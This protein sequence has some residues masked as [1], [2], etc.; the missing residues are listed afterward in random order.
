MNRRQ[1][2][3]LI[4]LGGLTAMLASAAEKPNFTGSWKLNVSKSDFGPVP[5]PEKLEQTIKHE[6]P[7]L[8]INTLNVGQQGEIKSETTY[9]T[10]GKESINKQAGVETK[11]VAVWD[12]DKL[13]IK[14]KRE[15]QGMEI[16]F[17]DT[18]TLGAEGKSYTIVRDLSTPQ[19]D[20]KLTIVM[21]KQ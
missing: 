6:D 5:P 7:K 19:G 1:V 9:N 14:Y 15:I 18:W 2:V 4:A 16:A 20:F 10:D 13:V 12:G 3:S 11:S 17:V 21:D 8:N